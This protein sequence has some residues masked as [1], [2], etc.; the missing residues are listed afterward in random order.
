MKN[1]KRIFHMIAVAALLLLPTSC[2]LD[3][4]Y[5]ALPFTGKI[6]PR[7]TGYGGVSQDTNDW[8]YFNLKEDK[9]YNL[10]FS[11]EDIKEGEQKEREDWDFAICGYHFRT[12]GGTS[13]NGMGAAADLG[14]GNYDAW[15]SVSQI[16]S[17]VEWIN[18]TDK[19][20]YVTMSQK[21]WVH[22]L[23][24]NGMSLDENPW[25]DPN[26]GPRRTLTSGN[27]LLDRAIQLAGPPMTYTPS[28]HTYVIRSADGKSFYKLQIVS[29][30]NENVQID[31]TGGQLS[32]YVDKLL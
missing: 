9:I 18:D 4:K 27:P 5:D 10:H 20:V 17:D 24:V 31:E 21:D 32:Y 26:S 3:T 14:F 11:G 1:T 25:F 19:D 2:I 29:W 28:Y 12:N 8:M 23:N 15:T 13:G 22:Y 30:Y 16:P 6:L 7:I